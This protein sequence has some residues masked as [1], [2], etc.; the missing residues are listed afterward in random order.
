LKVSLSLEGYALLKVAGRNQGLEGLH[1]ELSGRFNKVRAPE[2]A[3]A[4]A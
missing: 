2:P 1:K 3:P 4:A